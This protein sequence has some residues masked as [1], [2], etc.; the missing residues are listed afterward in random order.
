MS[1]VQ[2]PPV[3][4]AYPLDEHASMLVGLELVAS[5]LYVPAPSNADRLL[6]LSE[7]SGVITRM[8]GAQ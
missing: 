4:I 8:R 3:F 1:D 6:A 2:D 5:L 7:L